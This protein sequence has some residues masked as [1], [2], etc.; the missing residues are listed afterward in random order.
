[1]KKNATNKKLNLNRQTIQ[2]LDSSKLNAVKAGNAAGTTTILV[3]GALAT[4]T[5][6]PTIICG[7]TIL[8]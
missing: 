3:S 1:M 5:S 7:I 4:A 8:L 6:A 2:K